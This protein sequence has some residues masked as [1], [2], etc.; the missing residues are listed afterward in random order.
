M[1]NLA[2]AA[3]A[4]LA[5][6]ILTIIGGAVVRAT[7]SGAGCGPHWPTCNGELVPG[8][9]RFDTL[10]E[11]T[12]RA[13]SG[14]ALLVV[15]LL[16]VAVRRRYPA[17]GQE[18]RFALLSVVAILG[19]AAIGAWLVLA[20]LV[21]DDDSVARAVAVPLHLVNTFFL[22][23]VL[24]L[25]ARS[26]TTGRRVV[27]RGPAR[28]SIVTGGVLLVLLGATGAVTALAGTLFPSESLRDGLA[29]DLA[30]EHFLT[31][32]RVVHP[33]VA[34]G[35]AWY[36]LWVANRWRVLRSARAFGPIIVA[37]LVVG[38]LNVVF[39]TPLAAQLV[40][41]LL[42]DVLLVALVLMAADLMDER[43]AALPPDVD[44][45]TRTR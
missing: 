26:L 40:H 3:W 24:T 2:R 23:A 4:V 15:I 1:T 9:D 44:E 33:F 22:L 43:V 45:V 30:R 35:S 13:F 29:A 6:S 20:E 25:L 16:A 14:V 8:F 12:H 28:R 21:A 31:T 17:G 32:L 41:L 38:V 5:W 27:W 34:V 19:E 10:V 39:L 11:F 42:A 7:G 37:Q 18:R 36:L